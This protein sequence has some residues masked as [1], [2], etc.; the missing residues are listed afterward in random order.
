MKHLDLFSGIGGF[1]QG[2]KEAGLPIEKS[3]F[4]EIDKH[5]IAIYKHNF[6]ES[7]YVGSVGDVSG[8]E[9]RKSSKEKWIVTFGSPCQDLSLAGKRKGM[10]GSR[11]SLFFEA[12]RIIRELKPDYFIWENV[13]GAFSSNEGLD[14]VAVLREIASIG[15]YGCQWELCNTRWFLPQNRERIY[16]VGIK[17]GIRGRN[18]FPLEPEIK[19]SKDDYYESMYEV[20]T[21][22]TKEFF[23]GR[24]KEQGW[25]QGAMSSLLKCLLSSIQD[26]QSSEMQEEDEEVRQES[27]GSLQTI[28]RN[29]EKT[30][31]FNLPRGFCQVVQSPTEA[32]RLLWL[33]RGN[34][35][36]GFRCVEQQKFGEIEYRQNRFLE[37]LRRGEYGSCLFSVQLDKGRLFYSIGDGGD[38]QNL[39]VTKMERVQWTLSDI[40][41]TEVDEK[42]FLSEKMLKSLT[43]REGMQIG[44]QSVC[45]MDIHEQ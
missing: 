2:L 41:E 32:M 17:G 39:C 24:Q 25:T 6:K 14:F 45:K 30:Q 3:Y 13:K 20:P 19:I 35:E 23:R 44:K 36:C 11:S 26:G 21:T 5:A 29:S 42:Y 9:L 12:T 16:L 15:G 18:L 22:V 28:E 7:E 43:D 8:R 10:A 38:W 40:L 1:S 33:E 37:R 27:K 34:V 4:S 31:G